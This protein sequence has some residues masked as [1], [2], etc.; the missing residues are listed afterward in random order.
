MALPSNKYARCRDYVDQPLP[1]VYGSTSTRLL[2]PWKSSSKSTQ[3]ARN[4]L[5]GQK[6]IFNWLPLLICFEEEVTIKTPNPRW[7][8]D[9]LLFQVW[10][11]SPDQRYD[12][13]KVFKSIF[14]EDKRKTV[15]LKTRR[16]N[17]LYSHPSKFR[18]TLRYLSTRAWKT[19]DSDRDDPKK[20]SLAELSQLCHSSCSCRITMGNN[21]FNFPKET[22]EVNGLINK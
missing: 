4:H 6:S 14:T 9:E 18:P 8:C 20:I 13:R 17:L 2:V 12:N 5:S 7:R 3:R 22:L 21:S 1:N 10:M 15:S 11:D 19:A 16:F